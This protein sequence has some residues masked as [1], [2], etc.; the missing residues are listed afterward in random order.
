MPDGLRRYL[1][2]REGWLSVVLL[3]IMSLAVVWSV[4]SAH[5]LQQSEFLTPIAF[6]AI[7]AGTLLGLSSLSVV[8]TLPISALVGGLTVLWIVGGEYFPAL[9]G[10]SRFVALRNDAVDWIQILALQGFAPQLTP[11]AVGLGLVLWIT[12]FMAAY[13]LFRHHRVLDAIL[14]LGA[15]LIVN[16]SS[17]LANLLGYLVLFMVAALLLWLRA[18]LLGR[19]DGWQRRRVNENTEVPGAIMRSGIVFIAGS[20]ILAWVLTSVAV[21]APL[22][23]VWNNLDTVWDGVQNRLDLVFGGLN[24]GESRVNGTNFGPH[25]RITSRR[26]SSDEPVLSVAVD[27]AVYLRATT[28]DIYTGHGWAQSPGPERQVAAEQLLFPRNAP[29]APTLDAFDIQTIELAIEQPSARTLFTAGYPIRAF[30]PVRLI[31]VGGQPFLGAMQATTSIPAGSSYSMTVALSEATQAQLRTSGTDYPAAVKQLYLGTNGLT[32]R[33]R[34]LAE[35]IVQT[36]NATN[37]Y[38]KAAALARFLQGND[39]TYSTTAPVS[40]DP[41]RDAVDFFLFDPQQGRIGFCEHYATAM[42]EMARSLGIPARLAAGFAP[43]QRLPTAPGLSEGSSVWQVRKKNAH[44]WAELYFPGYGWQIFEATKTIAPVVRLQGR[45]PTDSGGGTGTGNA[46]PPPLDFSITGGKVT[47]LPGDLSNPIPGGVKPGETPNPDNQGNVTGANV[48]IL[49]AIILG[50]LG[51]ALWRYRAVRKQ[52]RFLAPGD[53][54]WRR[55]A[56]AADRAGVAQRPS[57]TI[58]EY[59]GWLEE[60]LPARRPEIRAIAEGKVWHSYSGRGI[61]GTIIA[62]MEDAWK[63][64]QLPLL[65]LAI[66]RRL[67]GLVRR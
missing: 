23:A 64:L 22:T 13:T 52:L 67:R 10:T 18:A 21:A 32:Q 49:V 41:N 29:E 50:L 30:L 15:A 20:V 2:P 40:G 57:E 3:L 59:A 53:R 42:V 37:P 35:R 25:L 60:Q 47:A 65:W 48:L 17:T 61:S 28:Y 24:S 9:A 56:L 27:R 54:Q 1:Q 16:L 36:A 4:Q 51:F 34:D 33:T 26:D 38:D 55:L 19:E 6:Y 58:F 31:E 66:R 62:R 14:L 12:G 7:L 44:A 63:R 46:T 5:W 43:G 11:Y 8:A 39:F 45:D